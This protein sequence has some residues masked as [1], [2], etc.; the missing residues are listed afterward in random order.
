MGREWQGCVIHIWS[1]YCFQISS[2]AW[3]G[4][5]LQSTS[6]EVYIFQTCLTEKPYVAISL[7]FYSSSTSLF[8]LL[9]IAL[10]FIFR[11]TLF[12]LTLASY[13]LPRIFSLS[14]HCQSFPSSLKNSGGFNQMSGIYVF[15]ILPVYCIFPWIMRTHI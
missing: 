3:L 15:A 5:Y 14:V 12:Q 4:S 11:G 13:M 1:R 6:G 7:R 10:F 9:P 8:F 2:Q